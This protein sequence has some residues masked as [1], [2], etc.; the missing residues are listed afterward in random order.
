M[1]VYS[2]CSDSPFSARVIAPDAPQHVE[3]TQRPR[4]HCFCRSYV[5]VSLTLQ[6]RRKQLSA[7]FVFLCE[8]PR[9]LREEA[10]EKAAVEGEEA[11]ASGR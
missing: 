4:S 1:L 7:Q 10:A 3:K 11:A 9:C 5:P 2:G 8:C 6:E